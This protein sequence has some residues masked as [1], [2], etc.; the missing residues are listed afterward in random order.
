[1]RIMAR[2]L[3]WGGRELGGRRWVIME[4]TPSLILQYSQG[5][6]GRHA[7]CNNAMLWHINGTVFEVSQALKLPHIMQHDFINPVRQCPG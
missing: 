3:A 2:A 4:R 7:V 1:M 6:T 5:G